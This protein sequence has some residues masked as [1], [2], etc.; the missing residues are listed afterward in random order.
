MKGLLIAS[1]ESWD[2]ALLTEELKREG[3]FIV[4]VDGGTNYAYRLGIIPNIIIGDMDSVETSLLNYYKKL[5]IPFREY[6]RDKDKTDFHLALEELEKSGVKEVTI[7]GIVGTRLDH[8][9]SALGIIRRFVREDRIRLAKISLGIKSDGYIF[10]KRIEIEGNPG[11]IISLI[12]MTEK[13]EGVTTDNLKYKL[14]KA[15]IYLEDSLTISNEI[16]KSPCSVE[17]EKGV[18]LVV[19]HRS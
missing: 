18:I 3:L 14:D 1:G 4:C 2:E 9:L 13:V 16:E 7:F 12:P 8:T 17:I 19:H 11:E 15:D 5:N 6:P 10:N